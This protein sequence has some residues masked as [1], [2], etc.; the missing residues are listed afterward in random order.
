MGLDLAQLLAVSVFRALDV[1]S[2]G[3][4]LAGS[5]ESGSMQLVEISPDGSA[6]TLT[7]LPGACTGRYLPGE[8]TVVVSHDDGGN[9]RGQLSLLR[10]PA[11]GGGPE[12]GPPETGS[13]ETGSRLAAY[14]PGRPGA[15]GA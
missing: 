7:A 13:Q 1:D 14:R 6:R 4:I 2:A 12:T 11:P 3:R 5:D 8:R 15:A 10:L 9:E